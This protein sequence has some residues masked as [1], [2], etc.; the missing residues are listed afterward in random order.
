MSNQPDTRAMAEEKEAFEVCYQWSEMPSGP[1]VGEVYL[2]THDVIKALG[3]A[4]PNNDVFIATETL[5]RNYV[6]GAAQ[7]AHLTPRSHDAAELSRVRERGPRHK[8]GCGIFRVYASSPPKPGKCTCGFSALIE[9]LE[10]ISWFTDKGLQN[11]VTAEVMRDI[12]REALAKA[13]AARG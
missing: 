10:K 8:P 5:L 1:F 7:R 2:L 4:L 6:W 12:A 13:E 3:I 11:P 9:A